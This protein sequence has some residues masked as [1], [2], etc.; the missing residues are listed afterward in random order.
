M[1]VCGGGLTVCMCVYLYVC[2]WGGG[3]TVCVCVD[4]TLRLKRI[5]V[6]CMLDGGMKVTI[7][8]IRC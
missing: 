3:L 1:C 6:S 2:V 5:S 4:Y 7:T 8:I